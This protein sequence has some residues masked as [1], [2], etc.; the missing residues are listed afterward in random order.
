MYVI[1][2]ICTLTKRERQFPG[3][4][5]WHR[6]N[7]FSYC[8]N[9]RLRL[10]TVSKN[11]L[12]EQ[13]RNSELYLNLSKSEPRK[14]SY[15]VTDN[16]SNTLK[17]KVQFFSVLAGLVP[18]TNLINFSSELLWNNVSTTVQAYICEPLKI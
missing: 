9:L 8:L 6:I 1:M 3:T 7:Y 17:S 2:S 4:Y 10:H 16:A 12:K 5:T 11:F 15:Q 14:V 18:S 13:S